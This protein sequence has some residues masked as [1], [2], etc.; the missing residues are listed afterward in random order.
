MYRKPLFFLLLLIALLALAG[1]APAESA[2][3]VP[4]PEP[5]APARVHTTPVP[6]PEPPAV[7]NKN[8][9]SD[10]LNSIRFHLDA[11]YLHIWFPNIANCDEA[12]ISYDGEVWMIDCGDGRGASRGVKLMQK[13][14]IT[15]IERLFITHPHHDHIGGLE[16]TDTAVPVDELLICYP[17]DINENMVNAMYYAGTMEIP[18]YSYAD[19]DTF[20]MGDGQVTLKFYFNDQSDETLDMNNNSAQTMLR[21]GSRTMLFTSDMERAG[22]V[23]IMQHVDP[24]DLKADV[25][26]YPHHGKSG[27]FE[28]W[29]QAINPS[30]VIITN[31]YVADWG[32]LQY[33][34]FRKIPYL[35]TNADDVYTHLWT[36]GNVWMVEQIPVDQLDP[37]TL[38]P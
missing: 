22:Q 35:L 6:T 7:V 20:S 1:A 31:A 4:S 24:A 28:D 15:E 27:P 9:E 19:G 37:T 30:L 12:I 5:P 11:K 8:K 17:E 16:I 29:F 21:F 10:T 23:A 34:S 3:P 36:E 25:L 26:K 13:L 18:V 2:A 32:G 38:L 33:L 14:G